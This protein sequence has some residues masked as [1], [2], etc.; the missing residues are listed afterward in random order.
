[1][2]AG[3]ATNNSPSEPRKGAREQA[4]SPHKQR[5]RYFTRHSPSHTKFHIFMHLGS[6]HI[7]GARTCM[8][9]PSLTLPPPLSSFSPRPNPPLVQ[10][11]APCFNPCEA[12]QH[13][14]QMVY[15]GTV[16]LHHRI[17]NPI[18]NALQD[19]LWQVQLDCSR[20]QA[21]SQIGSATP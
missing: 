12:V 20:G 3:Q 6:L 9:T 4:G 17:A 21:V 14:L 8:H 1:M 11:P 18:A 2:R 16:H 10:L 7:H 19:V 15:P 5:V 13:T